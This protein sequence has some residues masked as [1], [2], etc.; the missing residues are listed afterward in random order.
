MESQ[1][2]PVSQVLR[3][4]P[5]S[6][7]VPTLLLHLAAGSFFREAE[8]DEHPC[9]KVREE[10]GEGQARGSLVEGGE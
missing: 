4:D 7:T 9:G 10:L 1:D 3:A 2:N 5:C 8:R 6:F